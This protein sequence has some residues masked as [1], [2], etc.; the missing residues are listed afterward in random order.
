[1]KKWEDTRT[2]EQKESLLKVIKDLL[3]RYPNSI[4]YGH[5]DFTNKKVC[6]SYDAKKEYKYL[7]NK[8]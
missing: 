8:K 4:V 2:K 7:T 1:M 5:R 6:P 3:V